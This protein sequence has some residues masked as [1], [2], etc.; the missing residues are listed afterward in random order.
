MIQ[1]ATM[2][3]DLATVEVLAEMNVDE[4]NSFLATLK[5]KL[6]EISNSMLDGLHTL[7]SQQF[8]EIAKCYA[9]ITAAR[10]KQQSL[11]KIHRMYANV[12]SA[13][14]Q[15]VQQEISRREQFTPLPNQQ[16]QMLQNQRQ[17]FIKKEPVTEPAPIQYRKPN[18]TSAFDG[19]NECYTLD[20]KPIPTVECGGN[21]C[22]SLHYKGEDMDLEMTPPKQAPKQLSKRK[23]LK[24]K[25][26]R[27]K[28]PQK[29][30]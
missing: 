3:L 9:A 25:F 27:K 17:S 23:K 30:I 15:K 10:M 6:R 21:E 11:Q 28:K 26:I 2:S 19:G 22:D 16:F 14:I 20:R 12:N 29:K 7:Q 8:T 24:I 13:L 18:T 5:G 1:L 4:L